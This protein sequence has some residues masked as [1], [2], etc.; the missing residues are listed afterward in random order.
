VK[1]L[2]D[3]QE[4]GN[5]D[6]TPCL[7]L[8]PVPSGETERDHIFLGVPILFPQSADSFAQREEEF[9]LYGHNAGL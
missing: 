4:R 6:W 8:L 2:A 7:N 9:F 1:D 5:C 3:A